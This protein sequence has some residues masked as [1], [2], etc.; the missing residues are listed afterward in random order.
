MHRPHVHGPGLLGVAAVD[1]WSWQPVSYSRGVWPP[2]CLQGNRITQGISC[3]DVADICLKAINNPEA[4]NKTFEV[5]PLPRGWGSECLVAGIGRPA[6]GIMDG[7]QA[8]L[9][10]V[11]SWRAKAA[12][13][14]PLFACVCMPV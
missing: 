8:C 12:R 7:L 13:P 1:S 10:G 5:S 4:R 6:L 14:G 2:V 11:G 3:A 9:G